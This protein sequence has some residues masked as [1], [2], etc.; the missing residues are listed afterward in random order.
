[1]EGRNAQQIL[2]TLLAHGQVEARLMGY[3]P[4]SQEGI[5][6]VHFAVISK[7]STCIIDMFWPF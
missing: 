5:M 3:S 7:Q 4:I 2:I 6:C 1:M